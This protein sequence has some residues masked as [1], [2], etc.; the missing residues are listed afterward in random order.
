MVDSV[1]P[2]W[3]VV[4]LIQDRPVTSH[5]LKFY[6]DASDKGFGAVYD[7]WLVSLWQHE[8]IAH[9][10]NVQELFAIVAAVTAWGEDW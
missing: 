9:A 10:N 8:V 3:N 5:S 1:P 4:K 7:R 6:T 2:L